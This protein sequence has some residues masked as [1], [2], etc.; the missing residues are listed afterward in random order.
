MY[1]LPII[2][3]L[4]NGANE[5]LVADVAFH[6]GIEHLDA[7]ARRALHEGNIGE[8]RV[9]LLDLTR[10]R[11]RIGCAIGKRTVAVRRNDLRYI[12][13]GNEF[14][15]V[16]LFPIGHWAIPSLLVIRDYSIISSR[17]VLFFDT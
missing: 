14:L 10:N 4:S 17:P 6:A 12:F 3:V 5:R 7:F 13:H 11:T 1:A 2:L 9:A 8:F 16:E 15:L